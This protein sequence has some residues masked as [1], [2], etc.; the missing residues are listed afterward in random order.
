MVTEFPLLRHRRTL[1]CLETGKR[2]QSLIGRC[3]PVHLRVASD[4][5]C[6]IGRIN[7]PRELEGVFLQF[8]EDTRQLLHH[9][10]LL[11]ARGGRP[12]QRFSL[13]L[14]RQYKRHPDFIPLGVE[15]I[16]EDPRCRHPL[17]FLQELQRCHLAL[18][19]TQ[20][21]WPSGGRGILLPDPARQ[22]TPSANAISRCTFMP[23]IFVQRSERSMVRSAERVSEGTV[24][25]ISAGSP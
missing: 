4:A 21:C 1:R 5:M 11:F 23:P 2:A 24:Q 3:E 10:R 13:Q 7:R 16:V 6:T 14:L 12:I 22:T 18:A 9:L 19:D 8:Y 25:G 17:D 20:R 15:R